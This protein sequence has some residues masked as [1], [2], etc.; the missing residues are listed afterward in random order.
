MIR[1]MVELHE[2]KGITQAQRDRVKEQFFR[3]MAPTTYNTLLDCTISILIGPMAATQAQ[4]DIL[5][6]IHNLA[7]DTPAKL[8][9]G[10]VFDTRIAES[11]EKK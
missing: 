5:L 8:S 3:D 1:E 7:A 4:L 11:I 6:A 9:Y 10:P 2:R